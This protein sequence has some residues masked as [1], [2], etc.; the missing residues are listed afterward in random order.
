MG[1][2]RQLSSSVSIGGTYM[3]VLSL[4]WRQHLCVQ[5]PA[6]LLA[7]VLLATSYMPMSTVLRKVLLSKAYS[8]VA[9]NELFV[10]WGREEGTGWSLCQILLICILPDRELMCAQRCCHEINI[11][12]RQLLC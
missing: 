8:T 10:C 6:M 4:H 5:V 3:H 11:P 12:L 2:R 7:K 9:H 1:Y